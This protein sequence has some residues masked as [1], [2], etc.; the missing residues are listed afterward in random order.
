MKA[1][2]TTVSLGLALGAAVYL[3]VWPVYSGFEGNRPTRATLLEINGQWAIIP[4]M[5]P[6]LVALM[7]LLFRKQ[8]VRIIATV[9]M[10]A[11]SIIGGMSIG[12]FYVPAAFLMLLATCVGPPAFTGDA[13]Q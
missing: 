7:P 1:L 3:L 10:G 12:L 11:F 2:L 5:F 4:V 8:V 9:L 6:V 13:G